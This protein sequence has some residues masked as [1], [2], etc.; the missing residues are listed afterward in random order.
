LLST[1]D[2]LSLEN[3]SKTDFAVLN[4]GWQKVVILEYGGLQPIPWTAG[5]TLSRKWVVNIYILVQYVDDVQVH[6]DLNELRDAIVLKIQEWPQLEGTTVFD[7]NIVSGRP[8]QPNINEDTGTNFFWEVLECNIDE[9][10]R[11]PISG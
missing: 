3:V 7:S 11:S 6:D 1:I 9:N 4:Y 10:V 5:Y 2:G 8:L